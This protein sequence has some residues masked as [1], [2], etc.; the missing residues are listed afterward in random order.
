MRVAVIGSFRDADRRKWKLRGELE[1]F[2]GAAARIG[3]EIA[4][5]GHV[6]IVGSDGKDTADFN[7]AKGASAGWSTEEGPRI[8]VL[9]PQDRA[10]FASLRRPGLISDQFIPASDWA[11]A[12]VFQVRASDAVLVMGGADAS[13]QAGLTAAVSGK[14]LV[15]VGG[16]GGAA[17]QLNE[18]LMMTRSSWSSAL[19][20]I[21]ELGMLQEPWDE[22]LLPRVTTLL[23]AD[24]RPRLL[25]IHGRSADRDQLRDH[26]AGALGLPEPV[27]LAEQM[28]PGEILPVKFEALASKVEGAIALGTPDD[29][30]GLAGEEAF[31]IMQNRA[32]QNVWL[33]IGWFWGRLGRRRV[34]VL[35]RGDVEVPSDLSGVET[36]VYDH[37]PSERAKEIAA[38][39]KQIGDGFQGE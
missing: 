5:L 21:D 31:R 37:D 10:T 34:L 13:F 3:A 27:I 16:F 17:R 24:R 4:R 36:Y 22:A 32:R 35:T 23:R 1:E 6:L 2:R 11:P 33:E 25:I 20:S 38:F 30:G 7:A 28:K 14:T 18:L 19:P 26:I 12:K 8:Q 29:I 15:C 9:A 39:V